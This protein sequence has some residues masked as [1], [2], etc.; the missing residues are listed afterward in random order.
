[1]R[2]ASSV[3]ITCAAL[4]VAGCSTKSE[5][6]AEKKPTAAPA[7]QPAGGA[8]AAPSVTVASLKDQ[9]VEVGCALCIYSMPGVDSCQTAVMVDG[10]PMLVK[11]I[12]VDLHD[13]GLCEDSA[14]AIVSGEVKGTTV[15]LTKLEFE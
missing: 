2:F 10:T 15:M 5:S 11:G 8:S 1:M 4:V 7:T 9:K 14:E 13:H 12:D 6:G 3:L